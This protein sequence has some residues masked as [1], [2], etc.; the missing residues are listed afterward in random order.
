[1]TARCDA[2]GQVH[3]RNR[4]QVGR[5]IALDLLG[6][7]DCLSLVLEPWQDFDE[8]PEES[9]TADEEEKEDQHRLKQPAGERA[10]AAEQLVRQP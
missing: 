9:V 2:H 7:V 6:D 10:S 8:A 5:Y 3:D 4:K 1:M